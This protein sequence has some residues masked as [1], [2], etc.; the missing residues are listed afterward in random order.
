MTIYAILFTPS[1]FLL[2]NYFNHPKVDFMHVGTY[3][4]FT[5]LMFRVIAIFIFFVFL[6]QFDPGDHI[7]FIVG[8]TLVYFDKNYFQPEALNQGCGYLAPCAV[9]FFVN[10]LMSQQTLSGIKMG[11]QNVIVYYVV[12]VSWATC[13]MLL[14]ASVYTDITKH[15]KIGSSTIDNKMMTFFTS[16]VG[17]AGVSMGRAPNPLSLIHI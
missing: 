3:I 4:P 17:I 11:V 1:L 12:S 14:L 9:A 16:L 10:H 6:V 13:S 5:L 8:C 2:M 7:F 15:P